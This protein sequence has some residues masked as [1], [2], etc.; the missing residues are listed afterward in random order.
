MQDHKWNI[1]CLTIFIY[2]ATDILIFF[3]TGNLATLL[4]E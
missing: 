3:Q 1:L 2:T 4:R